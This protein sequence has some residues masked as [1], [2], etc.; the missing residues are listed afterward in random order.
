MALMLIYAGVALAFFFFC[1]LVEAV[2]LS[3]SPFFVQSLEMNSHLK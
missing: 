1:S 2:L 3:I